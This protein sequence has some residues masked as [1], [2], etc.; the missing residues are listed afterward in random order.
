MAQQDTVLNPLSAVPLLGSLIGKVDEVAGQLGL[1]LW[2]RAMV[3]M[4]ITA[5][6][7]FLLLRLL[8]SRVLPWASTVLVGP[9]VSLAEGL[10]VALLLPDLAISRLSRR[11]GRIP[12]EAVYAYGRVVMT[13]ID[14]IQQFFRRIL[15]TLEHV[16]R[17]R[18]WML[19]ALLVLGFVVWNSVSC[20]SGSGSTCRTPVSVW[21]A[22][23]HQWMGA[24]N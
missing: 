8:T 4:A 19:I 6:L 2:L 1:P 23:F 14:A 10:R 17:A 24:K 18:R 5:S 12:P 13:V 15:P 9:T 20:D 21:S 3:E 7:A 16:R 22:S 11:F